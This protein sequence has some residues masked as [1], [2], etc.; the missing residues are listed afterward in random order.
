MVG[1]IDDTSPTYIRHHAIPN[2]NPIYSGLEPSPCPMSCVHTPTIL[3]TGGVGSAIRSCRA[4][5]GTVRLGSSRVAWVCKL[6]V[7]KGSMYV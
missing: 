4:A 7:Y 2:L 1:I 5:R 3:C 6:F